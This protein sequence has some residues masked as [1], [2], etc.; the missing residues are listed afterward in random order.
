MKSSVSTKRAEQGVKG[1]TFKVPSIRNPLFPTIDPP[2]LSLHGN[3]LCV[4]FPR[5]TLRLLEV[6]RFLVMRHV[7]HDRIDRQRRDYLA[8]LRFV[9]RMVDVQRQWDGRALDG[10]GGRVRQQ[11]KLRESRWEEL[12]DQGRALCFRG[13]DEGCE[14]FYVV[15]GSE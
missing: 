8:D 11:G 12:D 5:Q 4:A 2:A 10:M 7:N 3:S 9:L 15:A 13:A 6:L 14:L 1:S